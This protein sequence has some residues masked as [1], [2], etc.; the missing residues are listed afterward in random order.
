ML[1]KAF[2][3]KGIIRKSYITISGICNLVEMYVCCLVSAQTLTLSSWKVT[4]ASVLELSKEFTI[5]EIHDLTLHKKEMKKAH[6]IILSEWLKISL[7]LKLKG[8]KV[9]VD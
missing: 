7:Q 6:K 3:I 5:A 4:L 2:L 9:K 1:L 8:W